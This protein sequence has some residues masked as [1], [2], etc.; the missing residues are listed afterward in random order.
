VSH[1][2][3]ISGKALRDIEQIGERIALESLG[4]A[5]TLVKELLKS[6]QSLDKSPDRFA[7]VRRFSGLRRIVH[8]NYLIFYD[9]SANYVDVIHVLHGAMDYERILFP[10]DDG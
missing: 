8:G 2:V 4:S 1:K 9:V 10:D 6:C 5:R 7:K 3:R